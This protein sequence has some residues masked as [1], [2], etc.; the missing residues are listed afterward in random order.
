MARDD[1]GSIK[2][3]V[4]NGVPFDALADADL[5][6]TPS[7]YKN[8]SV[9]TS[10]RNIR[11]RTRQTMDVKSVTI[12]AN[13]DERTALQSYADNEVDITLAYTTAAGDTYRATGW[14][15]FESWNNQDNKATVTLFPRQG[16][17][18]FIAV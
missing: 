11:K 4:L 1:S 18:S 5:G 6:V 15:D 12:V 13:G 17:D 8:E 3:V 10:G 14:I 7:R 16:W 9:A 2:S